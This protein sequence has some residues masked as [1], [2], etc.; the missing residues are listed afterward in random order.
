MASCRKPKPYR[1][2]SLYWVCIG[3]DHIS[4]KRI[5]AFETKAGAVF[6]YRHV[7]QELA[8]V[9][10]TIDGTIHVAQRRDALVEYPDFILSLGPRG[11]VR[12]ERA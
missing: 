6:H 10:Q 8:E 11:G 9:G 12:V 2:P 7:A 1:A 5:R 3:T 4:D